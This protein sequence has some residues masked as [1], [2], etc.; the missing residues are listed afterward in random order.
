MSSLPQ[1][2]LP[3]NASVAS[4]GRLSIAGC[5]VLDLAREHGTPL[6]VYDEAHM[7]E[8]CRQARDAFDG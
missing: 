1:Y 3:D 6:F 7:R 4:D 5:D 2:L 8:R